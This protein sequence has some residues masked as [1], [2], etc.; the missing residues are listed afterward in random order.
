MAAGG[1][2]LASWTWIPLS[3][4]GVLSSDSPLRPQIPSPPVRG[5]RASER[6]L[7]VH[8]VAPLSARAPLTLSLSRREREPFMGS[9]RSCR[10]GGAIERESAP[11]PDPLPPGRGDPRKEREE[12]LERREDLKGLQAPPGSGTPPRSP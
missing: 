12:T 2:G 7:P 8:T 4:R 6:G 5:E 3:A 1:P 11:H 9:R 10:H